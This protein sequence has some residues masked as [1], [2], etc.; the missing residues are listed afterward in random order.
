ML[1]FKRKRSTTKLIALFLSFFMLLGFSP[2][3]AKVEEEQKGITQKY[4]QEFTFNEETETLEPIG[5]TPY[6]TISSA[7]LRIS[8]YGSPYYT[9]SGSSRRVTRMSM[10]IGWE[11]LKSPFNKMEDTIISSWGNSDTWYFDSSTFSRRVYYRTTGS[12]P[13]NWTLHSTNYS[14]RDT[15]PGGFAYDQSLI[16]TQLPGTIPYTKGN[17]TFDLLPN[18]TIYPGSSVNFFVNYYHKIIG[19]GQGSVNLSSVS[20]TGTPNLSFGFSLTTTYDSR[21]TSNIFYY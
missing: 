21:G 9:G 19:V 11:W 17:Y 7:D 6:G 13:M 20:A 2:V 16:T 3:S 8:V 1:H 18:K 12:F 10:N 14:V 15:K 4:V 5:P